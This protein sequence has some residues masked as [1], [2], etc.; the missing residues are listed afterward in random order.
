MGPNTG[1]EENGVAEL[2]EI[3]CSQSI[4]W[5]GF[6]E[7]KEFNLAMLA[8]Q[9]WRLQQ[10]K[11]SLLYHVLKSKYF[12][13]CEFSQATLGSNPSFTWCN[14]MVAQAIVNHGLH[15]RIGNGEKVRVW[16]DKWL[17]TPSMYRVTSPRMFLQAEMLVCDLIYWEKAYWKIEAIDALLLPHEA[18]EIKKIPPSSR[19]PTDKQIWACGPNGLFTVCN[20]YWVA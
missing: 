5:D 9:G 18:E 12:Q 19:L 8:K 11:N 15:W 16:G 2:G 1:G 3:V 20:A 7:L 13:N 6:Q 14:I 17:P 10:R 4:W